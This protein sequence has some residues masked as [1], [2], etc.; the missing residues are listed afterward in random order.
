MN[1]WWGWAVKRETNDSIGQ[2]DQEG[3]RMFQRE[4]LEANSL[5][6]LRKFRELVNFRSSLN[7]LKFQL[8]SAYWSPSVMTRLDCLFEFKF[9]ARHSLGKFH[10]ESDWKCAVH[11]TKDIFD[12]ESPFPTFVYIYNVRVINIIIL[13]RPSSNSDKTRVYISMYHSM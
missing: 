8:K 11:S 9:N 4:H 13:L 6:G 2:E 3:R 5:L 10:T 1:R 7:L 12:W